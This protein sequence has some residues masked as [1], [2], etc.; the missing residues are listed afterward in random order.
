[1]I[2]LACFCLC[3]VLQYQNILKASLRTL[4]ATG[5]VCFKKKLMYRA[6][7]CIPETG[8]AKSGSNTQDATSGAM[9]SV[10]MQTTRQR[11]FAFSATLNNC[12]TRLT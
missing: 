2:E 9:R 5:N 1:V 11:F 6:V 10:R 3:F 8:V 7:S 12:S 4:V